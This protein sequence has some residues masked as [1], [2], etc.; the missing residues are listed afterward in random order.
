MAEFPTLD[1]AHTVIPD[2][3][4]S[5]ATYFPEKEAV[6]C[7]SVRRSWKDF[8]RNVDR[9]GNA[10][11]GAG[12]RLGDRIAILM[13]NSIE[14]LEATFGVIACGACAVPLSGLLT[15]DQLAT[16]IDDSGAVGI[17]ATA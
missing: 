11:H 7:G 9:V 1:D 14:M 6:V 12:V 10:L 17:F 13:S 4:R 16:L 15:G 5:H 3:I 2:V 8:G